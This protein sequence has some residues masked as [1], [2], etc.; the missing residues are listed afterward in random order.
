MT[1]LSIEVRRALA[2]RLVQV[3]IGLA[4]AATGIVSVVTY[5]Q[6][7][8]PTSGEPIALVDL[9]PTSGEDPILLMTAFFLA[10]GALLAGAS[11]V[12]AEWRAGSI[13]TLLTWEPRRL[14]VAASK[15]GSAALA[16][17]VIGLVLQVVFVLA[18]LPALLD[19]GST[20]GADAAWFW[21]MV[22][23]ITRIAALTGLSA[24]LGASLA[25]VGRN[26]AV[27]LGA[28]FVELNL[29]EGVLR[30]WKP[31]LGR[32]LLSENVAIFVLGR[33][34]ED[35]PFSR[36][37]LVAAITL[38]AYVGAVAVVAAMLFRRRDVAT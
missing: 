15:I 36:P 10:V 17:G 25:M 13:T 12:G 20:A 14:R 21:G 9:W 16:A 19:H 33:D 29:V 4:L 26:T 6:T 34:V 18:L 2:R 23:G 7:G 37:P 31:G 8:R 5:V 38:V 24:A 3:L 22:G 11:V 1:L 28:A 30:A 32:W 35:L 27:A